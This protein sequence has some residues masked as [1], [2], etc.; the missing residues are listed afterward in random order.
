MKK[1]KKAQELLRTYLRWPL[2][3]AVLWIAAAFCI[4][5]V[6]RRAGA[7]AAFFALITAGFC[8]HLFLVG[9]KNIQKAMIS[10]SV[11]TDE[12][13]KRLSDDLDV[14]YAFVDRSGGIAWMN[15]AMKDLLRERK[16]NPKRLTELF[17]QLSLD[18]MN[19]I[20]ESE[21][22]HLELDESRFRVRITRTGEAT[23]RI[24]AVYQFNAFR[25]VP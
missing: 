20:G 12:L 3:P 19:R 21:D 23:D 13:Q 9:R 22:Y 5:C 11:A 15:K 18:E 16:K 10:W 8:G 2:I 25:Q 7:V 24:F 6:D 1:E 17:P 4:A 14:P